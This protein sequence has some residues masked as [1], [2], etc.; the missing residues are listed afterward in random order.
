[1]TINQQADDIFP[2]KLQPTTVSASTHLTLIDPLSDPRWDTF[3]HHHPHSSVFHT[4]A[5]ARV[6]VETYG[7]TPRYYTLQTADGTIQAAWPTMLVTSP[8]TG[9][10]LVSLPFCDH[11]HP[12]ITNQE[13]AEQLLAAIIA[14]QEQVGASYLE[15]RGWPTA[16]LP[17]PTHL[18]P[19]NYYCHHVTLLETTPTALFE[20]L[21]RSTRQNIR[22]AERSGVRIRFA[23]TRSDLERF[24]TLNLLLR[25]R[26]GMLPQPFAFFA[27]IDRHMLQRSLGFI[28][29]AELGSQPVAAILGLT[30]HDT[31][32]NKFAVSDHTYWRYHPN[33]LL[34]WKS[35][36][37]SH[38]HG[39]R[40]YD[41]GRC[42]KED[43]GLECFKQ[44]WK[45]MVRS[46]LPYY[47]Y[48]APAGLN[49]AQPS[50]MKKRLLS[51]FA[52]TA[53]R[54]VFELAGK[55][56]YRHLG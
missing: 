25:R 19:T 31:V 24:Y 14:D 41:L 13:Q 9:T 5:W 16:A 37:W 45:P 38:Q 42:S 17:L 56:L 49:V 12:L 28:L 36:E 1:M 20:R 3:V 40:R 32:T 50:G 11:C 10:R 18:T 21:G 4:S 55:L 7:Y 23:E 46:E 35:I 43:T 54:L 34:Y 30:H 47:Y 26:H 44:Q 15:V 52:H 22:K 2:S 39:F 53:P 29:L 33:Y 48:P 6:L 8:L 51:T 27:A